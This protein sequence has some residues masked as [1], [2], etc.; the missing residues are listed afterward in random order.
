V[1]DFAY[2]RV[3]TGQPMSGVFVVHDRV[4]VRQVVEEL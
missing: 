4:A 3:L 2:A 1:P